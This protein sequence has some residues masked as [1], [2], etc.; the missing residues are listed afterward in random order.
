[1]IFLKKNIINS[2]ILFLGFFIILLTLWITKIFGKNVYYVEILYNIHVGYEGFK[3]SPNTYKIDFALYTVF[4]ALFLS[5]LTIYICRKIKNILSFSQTPKKYLWLNK[6]NNILRTLY[7]NRYLKILLFNYSAF[8]IYSSLFF[9]LQFGFFEYFEKNARYEDYPNL[10]KNPYSIKYNEPIDKKN[11]ILFYVESLEYDV[12]KLSNKNKSN[13]IQPF[14]EI[15]GKNIYDFKHAPSTSFSI[16]GVVASQCSLPFNVVINS[17]LNKIPKEKLFCLSDVLAKQNYDQVFYI[18]VDKQFQSFGAFKERHGYEVNDVNVIKKDLKLIEKPSN[19]M[20]WGGGVYDSA[21]LNHAKKEIIKK[22]NAGKKFNFTIINTDTHH[23]YG[24]SPECLIGDISTESLQAHEAYKCSGTIIK[25]FFD[26]LDHMG[27]LENTLV[28][29]MGDHLAYRDLM[30]SLN[31]Q[32]KR[33]VYFKINS[34]KN[35]TRT[36]L[37]HFDVAPTI[38]D[39]LGILPGN[40]KQFGFGISLFQDKDKFNYN[41]HYN[42]V[43]RSDI[44]SNFYVRRL[45]KFVPPARTDGLDPGPNAKMIKTND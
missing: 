34:D 36:K 7:Y 42:L 11:L 15:K 40:I 4:P 28:V 16:A 22:H 31:K 5:V 30:G 41:N 10:Y 39:E 18:S 6:Y 25:K 20:A 14:N 27:I 8:L 23:P 33:N 9:L 2:L 21:L 45:L 1:M 32:E 24:Y 12:S 13:P 3:N 44:L 37:N 19:E 43:M 38:L 35:F 26:D 29:I 17:N